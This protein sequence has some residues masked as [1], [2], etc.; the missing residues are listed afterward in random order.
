MDAQKLAET[1][2][3]NLCPV[4]GKAVPPEVCLCSPGCAARYY[5]E[6][7]EHDDEVPGNG[8]V[9]ELVRE[10]EPLTP[11]EAMRQTFAA[12]YASLDHLQSLVR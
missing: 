10:L 11:K 7:A 6:H 1:E 2:R 12:I 9:E 8:V 4:C 3:P 5:D